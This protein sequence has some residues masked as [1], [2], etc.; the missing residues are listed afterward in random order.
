[1][2]PVKPHRFL[3]FLLTVCA[4]VFIVREPEKAAAAAISAMHGIGTIADALVTFA[5]RLG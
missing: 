1:M 4:L 5:S 2:L 3:P